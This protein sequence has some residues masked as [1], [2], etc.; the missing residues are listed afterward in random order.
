[1]L[2]TAA[3]R[4]ASI[5]NENETGMYPSAIGIPSLAPFKN[6]V[7]LLK[8]FYHSELFYYLLL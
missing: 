3:V 1:M 5:P 6:C 4:A 7:A 2:A 8:I